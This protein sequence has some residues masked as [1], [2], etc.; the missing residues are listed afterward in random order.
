MN[1]FNNNLTVVMFD[2][3]I[4]DLKAELQSDSS[5][6]ASSLYGVAAE[7]ASVL[8]FMLTDDESDFVKTALQRAYAAVAARVSAYLSPLSGVGEESCVVALSLPATRHEGIDKL[9]EYEIRRAL[10]THAL[11]QWY[12]CKVPDIA[13]RQWQLHEAALSMVVHDVYMAYGGMKRG[14]SYF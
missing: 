2:Y 3:P 5:Y 9:I 14:C 7:K 11:S 10:V 8:P 12:E 6:I 1:T 13:Q 4:A